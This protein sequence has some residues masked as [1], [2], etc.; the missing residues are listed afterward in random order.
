MPIKY[1]ALILIKFYQ[2]FISPHKGFSCA[3]RIYTG[4]ASCSVLGYRAIRFWGLRR[5]LSVL[6]QRLV[7]CGV[8]HSRYANVR[9]RQAGF[10]DVGCDVPCD[11][12]TCEHHSCHLG[13]FGD[14]LSNCSSCSNC[15]ADC[16]DW[17]SRKTKSTP[18]YRHIPPK[19][20]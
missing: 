4:N 8:A 7:K 5:G 14:L 16:G 6:R 11:L 10:I 20:N 2:K 9:H 12:P 18:K 3:Y 1:L 17:R 15:P 19:K 13:E